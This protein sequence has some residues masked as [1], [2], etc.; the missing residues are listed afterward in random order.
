MREIINITIIIKLKPMKIAGTTTGS[1]GFDAFN[2]F[3]TFEGL[4]LV[5]VNSQTLVATCKCYIVGQGL[6]W[7][8]FS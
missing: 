5:Q 6:F 8:S 3:L 4:K 2:Q 1:A 7:C